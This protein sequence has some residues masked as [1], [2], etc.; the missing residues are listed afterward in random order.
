ML[1]SSLPPQTM[2]GPAAPPVAAIAGVFREAITRAFGPGASSSA[3]ATGA[4]E[5]AKGFAAGERDVGR[6]T[7][8][9]FHARHRARRG[10]PITGQEIAAA[11]EWRSIRDAVTIPVLNR[12]AWPAAPENPTPADVEAAFGR[13]APDMRRWPALAI[14]LDRH[15]GHVPLWFLLGWIA[16]ESGGFIGDRTSLDERGFFQI[17]PSESADIRPPIDHSRLSIDPDYSVEAGVRLVNHYSSLAR[18][19]FLYI[20]PDSELFWRVVKLQ[21]AMGSGLAYAMLSTM[22]RRGID[23]TWDAI[24]AFEKGDG[25]GLHRLMMVA[26]GRF[27]HN[28]DCVVQRGHAIA[29]ALGR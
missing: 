26:P 13:H 3:P 1:T 18:Q 19:R 2:A 6:L 9:I 17:H 23:V 8:M 21:H 7:D 14:L 10:R 27:A 28:V 20:A 15:R 25:R 29:A 22:R 11:S 16:Q 24:K 5:A 4:A 12:V